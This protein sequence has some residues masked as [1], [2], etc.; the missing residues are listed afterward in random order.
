MRHAGRTMPRR[1]FAW[2]SGGRR[3]GSSTWMSLA[4]PSLRWPRGKLPLQGC[5]PGAEDT[6]PQDRGYRIVTRVVDMM[7]AHVMTLQGRAQLAAHFVVMAG[8]VYG[9][10]EHITSDPPE[11]YPGPGRAE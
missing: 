9:V 8:I 3:P 7:M 4:R 2:R 11:E 10:V 1:C 5:D 6:I